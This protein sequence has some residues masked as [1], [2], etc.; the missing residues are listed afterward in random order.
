MMTMAM[1]MLTVMAICHHYGAWREEDA[2]V[3]NVFPIL[4]TNKVTTTTTWFHA[5]PR[6]GVL[7]LILLKPHSPGQSQQEDHHH[8]RR[9]R[10]QQQQQQCYV[11][12]ATTKTQILWIILI[13]LSFFK[14]FNRQFLFLVCPF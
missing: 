3:C 2:K 4:T 6:G 7:P 11:P 8:H 1:M 13:S 5:Q 14:I 12:T 9:R 10:Q